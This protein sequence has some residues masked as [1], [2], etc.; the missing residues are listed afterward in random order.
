MLYALCDIDQN[1]LS[2]IFEIVKKHDIGIL[3][4]LS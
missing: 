3:C 1:D 2:S 4:F